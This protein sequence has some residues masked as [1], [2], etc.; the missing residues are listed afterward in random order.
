[1]KIDFFVNFWKCNPRFFEKF[2]FKIQQMFGYIFLPP[3][4]NLSKG[5]FMTCCAF[6]YHFTPKFLS[7]IFYFL[8]KLLFFVS[9]YKN[10]GKNKIFQHPDVMIIIPRKYI[11]YNPLLLVIK[12]KQSVKIKTKN[13]FYNLIN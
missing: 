7:F 11:F 2:N 3:S 6:R 10:Y 4:F 1:M 13:V 9:G 8:W 5:E 12:T